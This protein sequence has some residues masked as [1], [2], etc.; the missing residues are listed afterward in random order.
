MKS[1]QPPYQEKRTI[2]FAMSRHHKNLRQGGRTNHTINILIMMIVMILGSIVCL[3]I[4]LLWGNISLFLSSSS[5]PLL[6]ICNN[7]HHDQQTNLLLHKTSNDDD[8]DHDRIIH[9]LWNQSE[10]PNLSHEN[11]FHQTIKQCVPYHDD[12]DNNNKSKIIHHHKK[13]CAEYIPTHIETKQPMQRIALVAIPS[14]ISNIMSHHIRI[15]IDE[16]NRNLTTKM[17]SSSTSSTSLPL[18][19]DFIQ[20][21]HI[22]PHGYGKTHGLTKIIRIVCQPIYIQVWDVFY[23]L[24]LQTDD[25]KDH[26]FP[27]ITT[28]PIMISIDD[29]KAIFQLI[30]RYHCR[31]SHI[32]AHTAILVIPFHEY[33]NHPQHIL[34]KL[35][36]FIHHT[37]TTTTT[38]S[39]SSSST[40]D[41]DDW[42]TNIH[43]NISHMYHHDHHIRSNHLFDQLSIIGYDHTIKDQL[44]QEIDKILQYEIQISNHF[45]KWPC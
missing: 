34:R 37:T 32:A 12:D 40:N 33:W 29:V 39:S 7:N 25:D 21:S 42:L 36:E 10:W 2:H 9:L 13:K 43:R 5:S 15:I 35:H 8:R 19:I 30:L 24:L 11:L 4:T 38:L 18:R 28:K 23:T 41:H 3:W 31:L 27:P 6:F 16:Y 26:L 1:P 22:P 17:T 20:T 45:T 44:I 14:E